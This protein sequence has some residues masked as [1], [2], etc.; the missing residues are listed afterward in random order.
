MSSG[1]QA[2]F[3]GLA[4]DLRGVAVN[5]AVVGSL[6]A[7]GLTFKGGALNSFRFQVTSSRA[8]VLTMAGGSVKACGRKC[9]GTGRSTMKVDDD[10]E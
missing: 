4:A 2:D 5:V 10:F 9:R 8:N 3:A 7:G 1:P 6:G